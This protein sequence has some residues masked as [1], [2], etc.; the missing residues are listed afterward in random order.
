MELEEYAGS[1]NNRIVFAMCIHT[2]H[3]LTH[4]QHPLGS[5]PD[6]YCNW[7]T[8]DCTVFSTVSLSLSLSVFLSL[9]PHTDRQTE[10]GEVSETPQ[11]SCV[12]SLKSLID[13]YSTHAVNQ[14]F[15]YT[16][17][18]INKL[19]FLRPKNWLHS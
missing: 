11:D 5:M 14:Q 7:L 4:C 8:E 16:V 17:Y 12:L 3:T 9:L 13:S 19:I 6:F 10:V 15:I 1:L 18:F 2:N